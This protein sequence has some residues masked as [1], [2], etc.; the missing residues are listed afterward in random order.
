MRPKQSKGTGGGS[1]LLD[2]LGDET[3][4]IFD[5]L[6]SIEDK[7]VS[8]KD[9]PGT[10]SK[11][12]LSLSALLRRAEPLRKIYFAAQAIEVLSAR[13]KQEHRA[14]HEVLVSFEAF[15]RSL[16]AR[17]IPH[18]FIPLEHAY[19]EGTSTLDRLQSL[20]TRADEVH[21][22]TGSDAET[23]ALKERLSALPT[24]P[25]ATRSVTFHNG[26][27]SSGFVLGTITV[28]P[29]SVLTGRYRIRRESQRSSCHTHIPVSD[30]HRPEPG[31]PVVH[32]QNGI[33]RF[34]GMEKRKNH[35]GEEEEFMV[36][37][38]AGESK[39][40][41]PLSQSHLV[42]RYIGTDE[43]SPPLHTLGTK[44][45]HNAK[46]QAEKSV[47][48]YARE[49]LRVQAERS[50]K[51]GVLYPPD[52]REMQFF[53]EE[54]PFTETADQIRA[55]AAVKGDMCS[56][57]AMDRLICGD[58][59]YG[60][61]EI[62]MRA[63][64]KAV[65]DGNKQVAV[66]VPTTVLAM[67]H[68]ET[69]SARMADFP[70][71]VAV[72]SRFVTPKKVRQTLEEVANGK[73]DILIGTHRIIS[74]DV[75]FK[76]L[77]LVIIDEEQR[78]GVRTKEY[79]KKAKEGVDCLTL[80]ATPI[81]RTLYFSL[82]G[83]RDMSIINTPP[84]DRLP[85][86][87]VLAEKESGVIKNA[88][89]RELARDGQAYFIHNRVE[90]IYRVADEVRRLLPGAR[91]AV[92]HGR[93][94]A[95]ALDT[96]FHRF[97]RGEKEILVTTTI[98]ENGIDIPNANT[99][100]I[101]RA[102]T[103]GMAELY[104]LRGRVGR[105]NRPAYA[106]FLIPKG[107]ELHEISRRRLRALV[108]TSGFGGGVKLAMRDLEIRGAGDL[109]GTQQSGQVATVGFHFYCRLLKRTIDAMKNRAS[110]GVYDTRVEFPHKA[111][112]P[113]EYIPETDLRMELYHRLGETGSEEEV[114]ALFDEIKDR[115]GTPPEEAVW[116]YRLSRVRIFAARHGF[117]L[118]RFG[119]GK[120]V[121]ERVKGKETIRSGTTLPPLRTPDELEERV[122]A[123]LKVG[124][125]IREGEVSCA[126]S[127][128]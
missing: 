26:Y 117:T 68:Y 35:L 31:D 120:L 8:I 18:L 115:F 22:I 73:V 104:Q 5:D 105:W 47:V 53:E 14:E 83:A 67:Q 34:A 55:I 66:L 79:L 24:S 110:P 102:D 46:V 19:F 37:L 112:L 63:A 2:H 9:M 82:V 75:A 54:F 11:R 125:G 4:V 111:R 36:I 48:G 85:I 124:F 23:Q 43:T 28:A 109:L 100:I 21:F 52:S 45:W 128:T 77:G 13:V 108:E 122:I 93:M 96:L 72:A 86:K 94:H 12:F 10:S 50:A 123:L 41:V 20:M 106:Y 57:K 116:L 121:V 90:S 127:S 33:G 71:R 88:L 25:T 97:K 76:D 74:K 60:K 30:F 126:N 7:W 80:S 101:D 103:Y 99:I 38:Y 78:F 95:H 62:A 1:T 51:G 89:L 17:R 91:I 81:P 3:T 113:E 64:F 6:V 114:D 42:S 87:T 27:L 58:V 56:D 92:A 16:R 40:Y 119:D 98:V 29:Y 84:H 65:I 69:F 107:R 118:L 49:L 39:L 15:G 44:K 70:V 59:G 61:T 32:F